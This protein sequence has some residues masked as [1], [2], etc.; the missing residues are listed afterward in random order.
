MPFSMQNPKHFD[1]KIS[2]HYYIIIAIFRIF[3]EVIYPNCIKFDKNQVFDAKMWIYLNKNI[4]FQLC[5]FLENP[6]VVLLP[7]S[8][9]YINARDPYKVSNA[10]YGP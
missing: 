3:L 8:T 7:P 6:L 10:S 9:A 4:T 2:W 1:T 5:C